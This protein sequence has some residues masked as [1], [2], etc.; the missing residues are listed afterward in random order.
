VLGPGVPA[1]ATPTSSDLEQQID[2]MWQKL[3]PLIEQYDKVHAQ[4]QDT[5]T[6][7]DAL[8]KQIQ[9]LQLQVDLAMAR[10]GA[11]SAQLYEHGPGFGL[12]ALLASGS[13]DTLVDQL[14]TIDQMAHQQTEMVSGAAQLRDQYEVQKKP[15]DALLGQQSAEDADLNAKKTTIQNQMNQLEAL[16]QQACG[17]GGCSTG[18]LQP[19]ICPVE[20]YG[21]KGSV[22]ARKAC[23]LIGKPYIFGEAG[24]VGYD[25]SGLTLTAWAAVGVT[26]GHYT[27]WQWSE[28]R[29]V[30][31]AQ[32]HPGDLVFFYSVTQHV[33]I[34][35]GGGWVVHAPHAGDRVRMARL[36]S[37]PIAGY[38]RPG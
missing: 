17:S 19:T 26:L 10:V 28:T 37:M 33:G 11:S 36:E 31:R 3:E 4:L 15:L 29:S 6:K 21:D 35:V 2:A 14:S 38:R 9:P 1:H 7:V 16:R 5:Q 34:Y 23:S 22:A 13:P 27:G 8:R 24:P 30:T 12:G 20:Y 18:N 32:L 25:C